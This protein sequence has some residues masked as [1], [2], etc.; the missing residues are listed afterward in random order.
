MIKHTDVI[1]IGV[2][3]KPH[4]VSGEIRLEFE[5]G[6]FEEIP[7][8]Y[9]ICDMEGI[10]VPFFIESYRLSGGNTGYVKFQRVDDL[11]YAS[12]FMNVMAYLP[13][14]VVD[15]E[16]EENI[17][18]ELIGFRMHDKTKGDIGVI[19]DIDETTSNVL[20]VVDYNGKELL[21]PLHEDLIEGINSESKIIYVDLPEGL[22]DLDSLD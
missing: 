7:S 10:L 21:I 1:K 15:E 14:T 20:F 16:V 5:G 4:G 13:N 19:L 18:D 12:R 11:A 6:A 3:T 2:F 17:Y 8:E 9:I 22:T